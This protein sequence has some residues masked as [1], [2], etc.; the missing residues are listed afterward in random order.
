M[1]SLISISLVA[2]NLI[3]ANIK[4][5]TLGLNNFTCR[6][7]LRGINSS[8]STFSS[9]I[10]SSPRSFSSITKSNCDT[11][12]F[13]LTSNII[14][15]IVINFKRGLATV[16]ENT[17]NADSET[18]IV[19]IEAPKEVREQVEKTRQ[20]VVDNY[21]ATI[22]YEL[23]EDFPKWLEGLGMKAMAPN[24]E[25]KKWKEII[26]LSWED[27]EKMGIKSRGIRTR[28]IRFFWKIKRDMAAKNGVELPPKE[29]ASRDNSSE[30]EDAPSRKPFEL[31]Y[32][33]MEDEECWLHSFGRSYGLLYPY[34]QGRK[35]Q[36][37][38]EMTE[39]D[40]K[41]LGISNKTVRKALI[42][43]FRRHLNAINE[44]KGITTEDTP[45]QTKEYSI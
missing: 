5:S 41:A 23:L 3:K 29:R 6:N 43:N 35:W 34:F 17:E 11:T 15:P 33:L 24:F 20:Y 16:T 25:G 8:N 39:D 36:Q 26:E 1:A 10:N 32:K 40:L 19:E 21:I 2:K 9:I 31:D 44:E 37:M 18:D 7:I 13:S 38:L 14:K 4:P 12:K 30:S 45:N 28:L 42:Q 27:L 22:N